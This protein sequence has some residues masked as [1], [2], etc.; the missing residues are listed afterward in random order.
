MIVYPMRIGTI[1]NTTTILVVMGWISDKILRRGSGKRCS[2]RRHTFVYKANIAHSLL[3]FQNTLRF[4]IKLKFLAPA[5]IVMECMCKANPSERYEIHTCCWLL[6]I[7]CHV[8]V[9]YILSSVGH[10]QP[11]ELVLA[12]DRMAQN[13]TLKLNF[14][15]VFTRRNTVLFVMRCWS[16]GVSGAPE[17]REL[18]LELEL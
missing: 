18:E 6:F 17:K 16:R 10:H 11:P 7:V 12:P 1:I 14:L 8:T 4:C 2:A 3:I 15:T 13:E 9:L 5:D